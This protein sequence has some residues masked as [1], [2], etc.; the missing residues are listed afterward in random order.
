MYRCYW[1]EFSLIFYGKNEGLCF[2]VV[3]RFLFIYLYLSVN[4]KNNWKSRDLRVVAE[5][6]TGFKQDFAR[7]Y[8]C[9]YDAFIF[10][11]YDETILNTAEVLNG[12][13]AW[14]GKERLTGD[15]ILDYCEQLMDE[16]IPKYLIL[17]VLKQSENGNIWSTG[18]GDL[19]RT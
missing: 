7:I 17:A 19:R 4:Q 10:Q 3:Y 16:V 13:S 15:D 14:D 1:K 12:E 6:V 9:E 2:R 8:D 18:G 5:T 11:K